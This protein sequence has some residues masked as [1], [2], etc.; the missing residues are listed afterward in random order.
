MISITRMSDKKIQ[1]YFS[2][3]EERY[4]LKYIQCS[5]ISFD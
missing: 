1:N 2:S 3:T 4:F 5:V